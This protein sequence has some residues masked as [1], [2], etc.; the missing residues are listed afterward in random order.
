[1]FT[2]TIISVVGIVIALIFPPTNVYAQQFQQKVAL[3]A[4]VVDSASGQA[5]ENITV[6][7]HTTSNVFITNTLTKADGSFKF[8]LAQGS[9][10]RMSIAAVGYTS[11]T[12]EVSPSDSTA[13]NFG[14]ILLKS[15]HTSLAAIT[16][17][18][19]KP[20]VKQEIDRLSYDLQA[21]PESK[22]S[23]VLEM[24][25][26][27]PLLSVDGEGNIELKGSSSYRIL[28]NGKPSAM[29]DRNVKEVLRSMPAATIQK[30]EVITTPPSKYDA[31]GLAGIINIITNKKLPA[32]YSGTINANVTAP[33]GGPGG[34]ASFSAR[35][36]K[37]GITA[38]TGGGIYNT[39]ST[40][41]YNERTSPNALLSQQNQ[42]EK[43]SRSAYFGTEVSYEIDSLHLLSASFNKSGSNE[44][45]NATQLSVSQGQALQ[46]YQLTNANEGKGNSTDAS[47]NYQLGNAKN[48]D[49]LFTL[50]YRY[51]AYG[52]DNQSDI[53]FTQRLNYTEP[54]YQ[55][56]D[57]G[58]SNEH[59][60]QLDYVTK[61]K[62]VGIEAGIKG[63]FRNNNSDFRYLQENGVNGIFELDPQRT[64]QF[65]NTQNIYAAYNT[66]QFSLGSF[67]VKA[68]IRLEHTRIHADFLTSQTTIAEQ[69]LNLLP[70]IAFSYRVNTAS[71]FNFGFMQR[72]QRPGIYQLNP[73]VNRSNPN[74]ESSGNP[75]L[76][77]V[78]ANAIQLGYSLQKKVFVNISMDYTF[79]NSLINQVAVFDA[80][81]NITR[82]TYQNTGTARLLGANLNVNYPISKKW[83]F[84]TNSKVFYG[85]IK[86]MSGST[87]ISTSGLMYS[88]GANS[89]YRFEKGWRANASFNYKS[90]SFTLQRESNAV[91]NSSFSVSKELIANQLT[92]SFATNNPFSKYRTNTTVL[93]GPEFEQ[94]IT[95]V[96]YFRS[97][98]LSLNYSF[99]KLSQAV[100]KSTRTIKNDDVSN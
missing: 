84:S 18:G 12:I 9:P 16:V 85:Q 93:T 74:V 76:R 3:T 69:Q 62:K 71:T 55:Q 2:K 78:V 19:S 82:S 43:D 42:K 88:I 72:I 73:F 39:P 68:G 99:G 10:Y 36:G 40:F 67:N 53:G 24:M 4:K 95:D 96:S 25:R 46:Q 56:N 97:F 30:I 27:V 87:A 20:L 60:V 28:V 5:L 50:S 64:N 38:F 90:P 51:Y 79:F 32:G 94:Y 29:M 83:S 21:D 54:A 75:E 91:T 92:F 35:K 98:R 77:P 11:R 33:T 66:Y 41:D 6:S 26:K 15:K 100:K 8:L 63:I 45:G 49:E 61:L 65:N 70:A 44:T 13:I 48:K 34:G 47:L 57:K 17:T 7:L 22:S 1:M 14:T 59:T 52:Y 23:S 86:G 58:N 37:L 80:A 81:T 89:G 31:E